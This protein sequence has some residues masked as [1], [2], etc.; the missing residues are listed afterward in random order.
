MLVTGNQ[1]E[2]FSPRITVT[3]NKKKEKKK[4][5]ILKIR[6]FMLVIG[7]QTEISLVDNDYR[8]SKKL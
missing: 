8:R 7:N 4:K 3:R 5:N 1:N 2:I 6:S